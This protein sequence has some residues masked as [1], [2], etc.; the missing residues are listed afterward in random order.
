MQLPPPLE[1]V[2]AAM[3]PVVHEV[4]HHE[5]QQQADP[6]NIGHAGPEC[7]QVERGH[8]LH[9]QQTEEA[10]PQGG[11]SEEERHPKQPQAMNQGVENIRADRLAI[12]HRLNRTPALQGCND[13]D[14]HRQLQQ[15]HQQPASSCVP[16]LQKVAPPQAEQHRLNDALEQALLGVIKQAAQPFHGKENF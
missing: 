14:H 15:S 5:V 6:G 12:G 1:M 4:K 3:D 2:L 13:H 9:T 7:I 10:I 11:E 16:I 8:A